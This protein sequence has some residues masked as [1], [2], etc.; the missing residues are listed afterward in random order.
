LGLELK[1][2]LGRREE[3]REERE[4]RADVG[5]FGDADRGAHPA[6]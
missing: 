2:R 6:A 5:A 3:E 4:E 1:W